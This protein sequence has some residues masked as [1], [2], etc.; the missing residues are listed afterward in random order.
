MAGAL[1]TLSCLICSSGI[2][3]CHFDVLEGR[4]PGIWR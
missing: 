3:S 2:A 4:L 1:F